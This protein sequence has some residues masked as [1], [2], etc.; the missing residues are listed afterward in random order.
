MLTKTA[1]TYNFET[2][3]IIAEFEFNKKSKD[4][5]VVLYRIEKDNILGDEKEKLC[6]FF[7]NTDEE[8]SDLYDA[9]KTIYTLNIGGNSEK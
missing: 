1:E 4:I 2:N 9:F 5:Y 3:S 8:V 6:S 7:I